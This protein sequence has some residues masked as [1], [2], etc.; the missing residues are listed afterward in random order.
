M[1]TICMPSGHVDN[2]WLASLVKNYLLL[3]ICTSFLNR[4]TKPRICHLFY[5]WKN[6]SSTI[7]WDIIYDTCTLFNCLL[8]NFS[9]FVISYNIFLQQICCVSSNNI[10]WHRHAFWFGIILSSVYCFNYSYS[11]RNN[12][13]PYGM[14]LFNN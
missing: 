2:V 14:W 7:K 5:L 9:Q 11:F 10:F 13:L 3:H 12:Y 4:T 1:S 8:P 6:L